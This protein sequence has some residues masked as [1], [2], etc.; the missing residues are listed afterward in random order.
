M[1]AR[2]PA[3]VLIGRSF[4]LLQHRL[5]LYTAMTLA[6]IALQ[7]LLYLRW[8]ST[9]AGLAIT[10]IVTPLLTAMV[11]AYIARDVRTAPDQMPPWERALE[12]SWAVIAIDF[13]VFLTM[14]LAEA[15]TAGSD[16]TG[17]VLGTLLIGL[18]ALLIYAD[19]AATIDDGVTPVLLLP[20]AIWRSVS[21]G[22]HAPNFQRML[23][24]AAAQILFSAA[25]EAAGAYATHLHQSDAMTLLIQTA[26][27][28][29]LTPP[30]AAVTAILYID[31]IEA[32]RNAG[33]RP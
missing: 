6:A 19:A 33:S 32:E 15:Y 16:L 14:T 29:L 9:T 7:S 20:M 26:L 10:S 11:Y 1:Q 25:I 12:R 24:L 30:I 31:A 18:T 13:V 22:F 21:L 17:F 8:S 5:P 28:C 23:F 3:L 2:V 27:A 4:R